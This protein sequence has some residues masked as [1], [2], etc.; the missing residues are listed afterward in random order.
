MSSYPKEV[1]KHQERS[2]LL[3]AITEEIKRIFEHLFQPWLLS[4]C[5]DVITQNPSDSLNIWSRLQKK[6]K[7]KKIKFSVV[8]SSIRIVRIEIN[9]CKYIIIIG[10]LMR[11]ENRFSHTLTTYG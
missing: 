10:L 6:K 3:S 4:G 1:Y 2:H 9:T 7:K 11:K 8:E 5:L